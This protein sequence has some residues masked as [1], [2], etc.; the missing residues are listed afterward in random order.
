LVTVEAMRGGAM[1]S[2]IIRSLI[3]SFSLGCVLICS[4][5]A[6]AQQPKDSP[7]LLGADVAH[8]RALLGDLR[9]ED[10]L[11]ATTGLIEKYGE[12]PVFHTLR[13]QA[14]KNM[15]KTEAS[16]AEYTQ[17]ISESER[18]KRGPK[19]IGPL[20]RARAE[21]YI[22]LKDYD[23]AIGDLTKG[24]ELQAGLG[25][26]LLERAECYRFKKNYKGMAADITQA[27][28]VGIDLPMQFRAYNGRA[29]AYDKLG[30]PEL[31][32]AD[33]DKL[34]QLHELYLN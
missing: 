16:I 28:K 2:E 26:T 25:L 8:V 31:A 34:R 30:K 4:G 9:N 3:V 15:L 29:E 24:I 19:I 12:L 11:I 1:A 27:L 7:A 21:D 22:Q 14:F 10:A 33:R 23:K 32:K 18:L 20:Y 13:A 17:A 6:L 5:N